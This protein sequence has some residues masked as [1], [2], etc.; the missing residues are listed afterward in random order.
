MENTGLGVH[1][2]MVIV[3]WTL[4]AKNCFQGANSTLKCNELRKLKLPKRYYSLNFINWSI[5]GHHVG[6]FLEG[7]HI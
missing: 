1:F 7:P 4:G 6:T 5:V 2:N 3:S